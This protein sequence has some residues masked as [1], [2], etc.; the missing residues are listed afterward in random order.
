MPLS[1]L[2]LHCTIISFLFSLLVT[3]WRNFFKK[4]HL[5]STSNFFSGSCTGL[6]W[7]FLGR[8]AH[9]IL[10]V[11]T[12]TWICE[13][14]LRIIWYP[15]STLRIL[16]LD[17][18]HCVAIQNDGDIKI[19]VGKNLDLIVLDESKDILLEVCSCFRRLRKGYF[20]GPPPPPNPWF[21]GQLWISFKK[22]FAPLSHTLLTN[23]GQQFNMEKRSANS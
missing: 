8:Q 20:A 14:V 7:K 9:T 6:C 3:F 13:W 12:S 17:I 11:W 1:K 2:P 4:P 16:H 15:L 18:R 23:Q 21:E 22:N 19:V 5:F 10:Q